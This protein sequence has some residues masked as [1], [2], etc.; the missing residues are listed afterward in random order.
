MSFWTES[1]IEPKRNFRFKV[2]ITGFGSNSV[3]WWAKNFKT[4]SY[5]ISETPHDFMDNK[6]YFPGRL[7]WADCSMSLVDPVSPNATQLT[8][9]IVLKAGFK[10][11]TAA[12]LNTAG[13]LT[14]MSKKNSVDVATKSVVVTILN[15]EGKMIE[16]WT[17]RNAWLKG[18]T[19][20]D[21]SYEDDGLRTIDMT[22]RYDWAEC[23]HGDG[24]GEFST[25]VTT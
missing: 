22:W 7:T 11:K 9:D 21:L 10:I 15:S 1:S 24:T 25:N 14:T 13:A 19:F 18:A 6:Y 5:D 20:S 17:L 12:D 16:M 23:E 8:N 4:P 3:I 2:E